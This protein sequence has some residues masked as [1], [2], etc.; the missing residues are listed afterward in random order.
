MRKLWL[1]TDDCAAT[2]DLEDNSQV[3]S[4]AEIAP[5]VI[6]HYDV[7]N[8]VVQIEIVQVEEFT[9]VSNYK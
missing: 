9:V 4:S 7:D 3:E 2:F 6:V 8:N 1:N 5:G